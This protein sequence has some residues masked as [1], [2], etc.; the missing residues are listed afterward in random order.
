MAE[1]SN[2][3]PLTRQEQLEWLI[4]FLE[5][6]IRSLQLDLLNAKKELLLIK[7]EENDKIVGNS[8]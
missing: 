3:R 2:I 6:Q 1:E 4:P 8:L 5:E 7:T